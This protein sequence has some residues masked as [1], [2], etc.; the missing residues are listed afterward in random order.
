MSTWRKKA[1]ERVGE[2]KPKR[3]KISNWDSSSVG[4]SARQ[5]EV[6]GSNPSER[7]IFTLL[8]FTYFLLCHPGEALQ[9]LNTIGFSTIIML[10][11]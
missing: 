2:L 11:Q 3:I 1:T 4:M 5:P 10:I 6:L 7:K 9:G 8:M